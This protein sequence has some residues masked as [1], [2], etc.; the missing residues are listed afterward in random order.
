MT[1]TIELT[2]DWDIPEGFLPRAEVRITEEGDYFVGGLYSKNQRIGRI[3][4]MNCGR[5]EPCLIPERKVIDWQKIID[6]KVLCEF[7][8]YSKDWY[9]GYLHSYDGSFFKRTYSD[10]F[11]YCRPAQNI[12]LGHNGGERP[13]P[14]GLI[15]QALEERDQAISDYHDL[16]NNM[17]YQ[18]NSVSYI[19]SKYKN[20][21]SVIS[22]CWD[23]LREFGV[24]PDGNTRVDDAI[25]ILGNKIKESQ[26]NSN[27]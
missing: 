6:N 16:A 19:Y 25:R 8:D 12:L 9:I 24:N 11:K 14:D 5:Y 7:S 15:K 13:L 23:V 1:K 20:C 10:S 18:G 4:D 27:E 26:E 21:S 2:G 17:V 22:D 3:S